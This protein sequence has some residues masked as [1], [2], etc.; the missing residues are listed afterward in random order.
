MPI[1]IM[2]DSI[3]DGDCVQAQCKSWG[4]DGLCMQSIDWSIWYMQQ[5]DQTRSFWQHIGWKLNFTNRKYFGEWNITLWEHL[6][7]KFRR[8]EP[9]EPTDSYCPLDTE[10]LDQEEYDGEYPD[11]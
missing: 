4:G 10:M 2:G 6:K 7:S 9:T 11:W 3:Y 5:H 8:W 1:N